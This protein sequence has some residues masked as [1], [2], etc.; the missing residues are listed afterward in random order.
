MSEINHLIEQHYADFF[1]LA[2]F[3][4]ID[5]T[6]KEDLVH[7]TILKAIKYFSQ[8]Q[9]GT[10]FMGWV[11][12]IMRNTF[13]DQ[14]RKRRRM[15]IHGIDGKEIGYVSNRVYGKLDLNVLETLDDRIKIP[16]KLFIEG[17]KYDEISIILNQPMGT[18]KA[19]I[20]HARKKM[21]K[22]K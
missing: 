5:E 2:G 14:V 11:N 20:F 22:I 9:K 13:I 6:R 4:E 1:R 12:V 19:N 10:N 8:Y 7:D 17:Y 18:V 21:Q 15:Q 16:M 3:L